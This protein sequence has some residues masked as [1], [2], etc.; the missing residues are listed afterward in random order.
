MSVVVSS[1]DN[2]FGDRSTY[3]FVLSVTDG[4]A[5]VVSAVANFSLY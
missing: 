4:D 3:S 5:V 1:S 2:G